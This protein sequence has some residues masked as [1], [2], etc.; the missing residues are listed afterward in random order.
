MITFVY[1]T[2]LELSKRGKD[3]A[4][5]FKYFR[6]FSKLLINIFYPIYYSVFSRKKIGVDP[7]NPNNII[8]S[9]T[10]FPA[11]INHIWL[12]IETLLRQDLKPN[13]VIL[14]LAKDQFKG[15]ESLPPKLLKLQKR[16]LTIRFCD[17][18]RSHKKYYYTM[19]ENPDANI[20]IVDDDMYYPKDLIRRLMETSRKYPNVICCNRGHYMQLEGNEIKPYSQWIRKKQ[21]RFPSYEL[22]PTGC[23]GVL[24]PP[25]SLNEE[26]FNKS[27]IK[28]LCLNADD[29]WLKIMSLRNGTLAVKTDPDMIDFIDIIITQ[30]VKLTDSNVGSDMNDIQ[31]N[32]ILDSYQINLSDLLQVR[33]KKV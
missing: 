24:Y 30:K 23:G 29:L 15:I 1:K 16:G 31:L 7:S 10:S 13:K 5:L 18:L 22:C 28:D 20:I 12:C 17:D 8:I 4:L 14:W 19:K 3:S 33:N 32:N 27:A 2:L 25:G 11:R 21:L 26:V 6:K 9:L